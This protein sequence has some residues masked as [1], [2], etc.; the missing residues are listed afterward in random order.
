MRLYTAVFLIA[1][2]VGNGVALAIILSGRVFSE[3]TL[4]GFYWIAFFSAIAALISLIAFLRKDID[5]ELAM[6][7]S[8]VQ[9]VLLILIFAAVYQDV[10][11][12]DGPDPVHPSFQTSLYFSIVT[13]TTLGYGDLHPPR[14]L[15]LV[16]AAEALL[17]YLFSGILIGLLVARLEAART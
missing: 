4:A 12:M 3:E 13:W 1:P 16:A 7:G 15:Q 2:I 8:A 9:A 11:L 10:G 17:G 14:A 6:L 5:L